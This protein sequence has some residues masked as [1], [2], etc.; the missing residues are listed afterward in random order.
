M[1]NTFIIII[2]WYNCTTTNRWKRACSPTCVYI[3]QLL[4]RSI[5]QTSHEF[6]V[7]AAISTTIRRS[8]SVNKISNFSIVET[9]Q[10][11]KDYIYTH[12]GGHEF[13]TQIQY[14]HAEVGQLEVRTDKLNCD[15][16][17]GRRWLQT[18]GIEWNGNKTTICNIKAGV[19]CNFRI[20]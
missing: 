9:A 7:L 18:D 12:L 5:A 3:S 19:N 13:G 17:A 6:P 14:C 2:G 16:Q 1:L 20:R 10:T 11:K 4:A 15:W 8:D